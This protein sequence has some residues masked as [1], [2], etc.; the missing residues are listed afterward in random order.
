MTSQSKNKIFSYTEVLKEKLELD[1]ISTDRSKPYKN[2]TGHGPQSK[3]NYKK[4]FLDKTIK[5]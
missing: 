4:L 1:N 2:H 5:N 3:S